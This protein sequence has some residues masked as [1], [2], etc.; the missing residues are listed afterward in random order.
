MCRNSNDKLTN[1]IITYLLE[2]FIS[3]RD[4]FPKFVDDFQHINIHCKRFSSSERNKS[5]SDIVY[6]KSF[7][8]SYI[9][10]NNRGYRIS[11]PRIVNQILRINC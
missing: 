11:I 6:K 1:N 10:T 7:A 8:I 3:T 9:R 2:I 5:L 4:F